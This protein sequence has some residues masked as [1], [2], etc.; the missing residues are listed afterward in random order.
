MSVDSD[1]D[2]AESQAAAGSSEAGAEAP[3]DSRESEAKA[4]TDSRPSNPSAARRSAASLHEFR[5][6]ESQLTGTVLGN[7]YKVHGYLTRGA[8][9]R[10]YLAED[11]QDNA[12]V[13]IKMLASES[14]KEHELTPRMRREAE[15]LRGID[16]PNVVRVLDTGE[17]Q[18]GVPYLVLEALPGETLGDYL[19][20]QGTPPFELALTLMRQAAQGLCAAHR[21]GVVHRDVKPDNFV[22]L[23][24][25]GEPYGLKLIDFG[26]AKLSSGGGSGTHSILGT[27]EYM[28]PEQILME[29]VDARTDVYSLGVVMFRLFTG[30]LPFDTDA[31]ADL[32]RHQLFS[33]VPPPSWLEDDLDRRLE[34]MILTATRKNPANRYADMQLLLDDLDAMVGVSASEV[35]QRPPPVAPDSYAPRTERGAEALGIL[36]QKFGRF[37]T[38]P[39]TAP[40]ASDHRTPSTD[41]S[42]G[43]APSEKP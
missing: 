3:V 26:M 28:A 16:H 23:G 19:R 17:T 7:R 35:S 24:P 38:V 2:R 39:P 12:P 42:P 40:P 41:H 34:R 27:V 21:A 9:A 11:L 13:A 20:R 25:I 36:A 31:P 6:S 14:I 32:L 8:T 5:P 18:S 29:A 33:S 4:P 43:A 37:A 10:V 30:H 15:A 1:N 22:L